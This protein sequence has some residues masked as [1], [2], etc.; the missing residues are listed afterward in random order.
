LT[1][2]L[3]LG[4]PSDYV[5][6]DVDLVAP[7]EEG[8]DAL[9]AACEAAQVEIEDWTES[10]QYLCKACSE[11]RAHEQHDHSLKNDAWQVR[12]RIGMAAPDAAKVHAVLEKWRGM[13]EGRSVEGVESEEFD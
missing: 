13:G 4:T 9:N 11:G 7:D 1:L 3:H 8:I 6:F 12:R 5:T 10:I 2:R